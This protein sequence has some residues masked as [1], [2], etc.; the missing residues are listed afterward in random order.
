MAANNVKYSLGNRLMSLVMVAMVPILCIT[1]YLIIAFLNYSRAYDEIISNITVA[2]NYNMN[3]KEEMDESLYKL[4]VSN[5]TFESIE[6]DNTLKNPYTLIDELRTEC[7]NL[8]KITTDR[9]SRIWLQSLLRNIDTLQDRVDDIRESQQASSPYEENI[10]MLDNNIYILTELIQDDIQHYIYYQTRS[11]E[12]LKVQ[13]NKEIQ[14]FIIVCIFLGVIIVVVVLLTATMILNS[15][16]K[17]VKELC[18]VTSQIAEGDFSARAKMQTKDE[19]AMLAASVNDM[20]ENLEILVN[21]I[22]E[23][24]RKMRHAELRLLQEQINPHFLYNTLDTIV[25][26][27]EGGD[28]DK[29][30][31]MVVALSEFFRLVLSKGKEYISIREE[32][33][34]IRGYLDI[35]QA[36]YQDILDYE[37]RIEPELYQYKILKLTLQPLVENSLY[38]GIKYK[39]AKGKIWITGQMIQENADG[40][41]GQ[42]IQDKDRR[43]LLCVQD[44]GVGMDKKALERLREEISRPCKETETGFGLAN[45]NERIRMNF[46][47]EYGMTIESGEGAGTKVSIIIPAVKLSEKLPGEL[48]AEEPAQEEQGESA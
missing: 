46:G 40:E 31:D 5:V 10:K 45:V 1:I 9:E 7:N 2:N 27:I 12:Q 42:P 22:K 43:I 47:M 28:P 35:Q 48:L 41:D 15:I 20:S 18:Q 39:R 23:D 14:N 4:V 36:R 19:V 13:L 38:H 44:N 29:A 8:M 37:I 24:E 3:F 32:E 17:P 16:T 25:W 34:H 21:K 6:E 26:L 33:Q 30:V 11:I